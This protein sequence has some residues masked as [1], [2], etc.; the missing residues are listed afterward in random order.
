MLGALDVLACEAHG[1]GPVAAPEQLHQ[2]P[3]LRVRVREHMLRCAISA[4]RSLICP[5][6]SVIALTSRGELAASAMP[7]W[8]RM[9]ARRYP[10]SQLAP[11][12]FATS[13]PE[14]SSCL[15]SARSAARI[16]APVSIATR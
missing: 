6:T 5:C 4:I 13:S 8:K 12:I 9:S 10:R 11:A 15:G 3:V 1:T 16:V 7:M 2:P 14:R